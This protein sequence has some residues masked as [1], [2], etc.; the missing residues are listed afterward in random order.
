MGRGRPVLHPEVRVSCGWET[1]ALKLPGARCSGRLSAVA[2]RAQAWLGEDFGMPVHIEPN[3]DDFSCRWRFG[4][5]PPPLMEDEARRT[6]KRQRPSPRML[7]E[8]G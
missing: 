4:V 3:Y 2:R 5:E 8:I 1:S 7:G 6:S